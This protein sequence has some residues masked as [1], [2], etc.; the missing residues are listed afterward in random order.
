[1]L[2]LPLFQLTSF[3]T[4]Q[5]NSFPR[6]LSS[7]ARTAPPK[8]M[9]KLRLLIEWIRQRFSITHRTLGLM[10]DDP[11]NCPLRL[12]FVLFLQNKLC[13]SH[14]TSPIR[15]LII[16]WYLQTSNGADFDPSKRWRLR[17]FWILSGWRPDPCFSSVSGDDTPVHACWLLPGHVTSCLRVVSFNRDVRK[18]VEVTVLFVGAVGERRI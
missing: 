5:R 17:L 2:W 18:G 14:A 6:S 8:L 9:I 3:S 11:Q 12:L 13:T 16:S 4:C 1:M 10:M 15:K 7:D